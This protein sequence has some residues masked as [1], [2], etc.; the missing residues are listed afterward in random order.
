MCWGVDK[1]NSGE[2]GGCKVTEGGE[3]V[4]QP[5]DRVS[6]GL[7]IRDTAVPVLQH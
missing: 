4:V 1:Y 5:V 7:C 3:G 6:R 2:S